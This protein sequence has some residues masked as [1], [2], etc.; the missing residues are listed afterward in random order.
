[1]KSLSRRA[2]I[3]VDKLPHPVFLSDPLGNVLLSN[4]ATPISMGLSLGEFLQSNV[5]DCVKKGYYDVSVALE[6]SEKHRQVSRVL[7]TR[8]GMVFVSTSTPIFDERGGHT[9][10][11]TNAVAMK[12]CDK[13]GSAAGDEDPESRSRRLEHLFGHVFAGDEMI[14]ESPAMHDLV[15]DGERRRQVGLLDHDHR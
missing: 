7:T 2:Q 6:A 10:T 3:I 5:K 14:A 8:L 13:R 9:L 11:V 15:C 12:E 4:P 1:M